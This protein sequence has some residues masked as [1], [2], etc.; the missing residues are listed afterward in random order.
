MPPSAL[1][2]T[3]DSLRQLRLSALTLLFS[4]LVLPVAMLL[5]AL[6]TRLTAIPYAYYAQNQL[7]GAASF[8]PDSLRGSSRQYRLAYVA[9]YDK[10]RR[11]IYWEPRRIPQLVILG[12]SN[13][14]NNKLGW[15]IFRLSTKDNKG[16]TLH[17]GTYAGSLLTFDP[18]STLFGPSPQISVLEIVL[19]ISYEALLISILFNFMYSSGLFHLNN[20]L[21]EMMS[22]SKRNSLLENDAAP[23]WYW[24]PEL[25]LLRKTFIGYEKRIQQN[26]QASTGEDQNKWRSTS[27]ALEKLSDK[28]QV[29]TPRVGAASVSLTSLDLLREELLHVF[30]DK[31]Q[32]SITAA[33]IIVKQEAGPHQGH[34]EIEYNKGLKGQ[35]IHHLKDLD[36][37]NI[38]EHILQS[39]RPRV[40]GT[41]NLSQFKLTNMLADLGANTAIAM[42]LSCKGRSL[43]L[44]LLFTTS[45][46]ATIDLPALERTWAN[47][48]REYLDLYIAGLSRASEFIDKTTGLHNRQFVNFT[49]KEDKSNFIQLLALSVVH[50]SRE[51]LTLTDATTA[52]LLLEFERV[53]RKNSAHTSSFDCAIQDE[54]LFLLLCH[55]ASVEQLQPLIRQL[56]AFIQETLKKIGHD[57]IAVAFGY[58]NQNERQNNKEALRRAILA[59]EFAKSK[60]HGSA[61]E[62]ADSAAVPK[63]FHDWTKAK[64][65][66]GKLGVFDAGEILQSLGSGQRTGK[67]LVDDREGRT[68]QMLFD[69]GRPIEARIIRDNL[70]LFEGAEA[71]CEYI[72]TFAA[73]DF[74]FT[75]LANVE[76]NPSGSPLSP[77]VTCLM[78]AALAADQMEQARKAISPEARLKATMDAEKRNKLVKEAQPTRAEIELMQKL[79][80]LC[81]QATPVSDLLESLATVP[82]SRVWYCLFLMQQHGLLLAESK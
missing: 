63:D 25:K 6:T 76:R 77:L 9:L 48:E 55:G 47:I 23:P 65:L 12:E 59:C 7:T 39:Q 34:F 50:Q 58:C 52:S 51:E 49:L 57:E 29:E 81:A 36:L 37:D 16:N 42:P 38:C 64:S 43:G 40:L 33:A 32:K 56:G 68:F 27:L 75:E 22:G 11:L 35:Q 10:S 46:P 54:N 14:F 18:D 2:K 78:D 60:L 72:T 74:Q 24:S 70:A 26:N 28:I 3:A 80:G 1:D 66:K 8:S 13:N 71:I 62:V 19:M 21:I 4:L 73:G 61:I 53:W 31:L 20:A 69:A 5:T 45:A 17:T 82:T 67:L 30:N 15:S 44:L 41:L 79:E